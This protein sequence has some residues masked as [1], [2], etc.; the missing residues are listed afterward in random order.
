MQM[1]WYIYIYMYIYIYI[2]MYEQ[3]KKINCRFHAWASIFWCIYNANM[4]NLLKFVYIYMYWQKNAHISVYLVISTYIYMHIIY[5]YIPDS[6]KSM[7]KR[8]M[9][10]CQHDEFVWTMYL[11]RCEPARRHD[12]CG[13]NSTSIYIYIHI[14]IRFCMYISSH[15]HEYWNNYMHIYIH[16]YV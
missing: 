4:L 9:V 3:T 5:I 14:Y 7:L 11:V 16:R 15:A 1:L 12:Q 8:R 2:N 13:W 6:W 10:W